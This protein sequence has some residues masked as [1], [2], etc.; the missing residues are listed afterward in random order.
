MNTFKTRPR[1]S[2]IVDSDHITVDNAIGNEWW[3]LLFF[4]GGISYIVNSGSQHT[5]DNVIRTIVFAWWPSYIVDSDHLTADNQ[6]H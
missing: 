1:P 2:Y 5:A 4:D 3:V 6:C